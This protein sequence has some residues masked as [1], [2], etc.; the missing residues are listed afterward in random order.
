[1]SLWLVKGKHLFEFI[2]NE[3]VGKT[4]KQLKRLVLMVAFAFYILEAVQKLCGQKCHCNFVLP[5]MT[6]VY[7]KL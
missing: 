6:S 2:R 7:L 3:K 1:M 4:G 5:K